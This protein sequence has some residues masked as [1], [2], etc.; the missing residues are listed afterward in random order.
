[1]QS[2][3]PD[4]YPVVADE[5]AIELCYPE[6]ATRNRRMLLSRSWR[7]LKTL[8]KA[9]ELRLVMDRGKKILPPG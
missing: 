9:G 5:D 3:D 2:T 4:D 8:E 1:M 6:S 7:V